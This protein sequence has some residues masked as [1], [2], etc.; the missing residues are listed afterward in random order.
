MAQDKG[1]S[2]Q[3]LQ[4]LINDLPLEERNKLLING[5]IASYENEKAF[6]TEQ[7]EEYKRLYQEFLESYTSK[8]NTKG[9]YLEKL[10]R[11]IFQSSVFFTTLP[12]IHTSTNEI[13]V[14]VKLSDVGKQYEQYI[15]MKGQYLLAE[16]KNY[17][18]ESSKKKK[19]IGV[20]WV[21]KFCS[22]LLF[23]TNAR[24]GILFSHDGLAGRGK[25]DSAKGLVR[26]FH[27]FKEADSD[28]LYI[29][30]FNS[31]DF[32]RLVNGE[33]FL[34]LFHQKVEELECDTN[35]QQNITTH[36]AEN[37]TANS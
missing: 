13:D 35:I 18:T 14:L 21:G 16:C 1:L 9:V 3:Q 24:V 7:L 28:K 31:N 20:T 10:V 15:D 30:D 17:G 6:T 26:K 12:N 32:E 25:W 27:Y 33:C 22:L 5:S 8:S 4:Q 29:L 19:T 11:F 2:I 23:Q 34:D 37:H 36:P